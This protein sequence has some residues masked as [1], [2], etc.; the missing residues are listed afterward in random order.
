[1]DLVSYGCDW[2]FEGIA[3]VCL[4]FSAW[5]IFGRYGNVKLGAKE[6]KPEFS[7]FTWIAMFFCAGIGAGAI[8]WA[9]VEP[10]SYL[11]EPPFGIE[12]FSQ[13]AREWSMAY[14]YFH[15]ASRPGRFLPFPGLCLPTVT[16]TADNTISR[17]VMLAAAY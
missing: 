12:P 10:I 2:M 6:D 11:S 13:S 3:F 1:M 7:T 15:W 16:I 5:L 17:P 4:L 8:Y 9:C 14:T